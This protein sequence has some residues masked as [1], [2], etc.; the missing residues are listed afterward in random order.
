MPRSVNPQRNSG[1]FALRDG[2]I[3]A[4]P[5][6]FYIKY[7]LVAVVLPIGSFYVTD[8]VVGIHVRPGTTEAWSRVRNLSPKKYHLLKCVLENLER[9]YAIEW[10]G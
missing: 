2:R 3:W 1:A 8:I 7:S 5:I 9:S 4:D 6:F 10:R